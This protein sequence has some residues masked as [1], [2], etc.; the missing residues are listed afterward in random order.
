MMEIQGT[1]QDQISLPGAASNAPQTAQLPIQA[2]DADQLPREGGLSYDEV[3]SIIGSLY[4]D[5]HHAMKVREEQFQAILNEHE[6]VSMRLRAELQG[7]Q[8][9]VNRLV[10]EVTALRR[11]LEIR[12]DEGRQSRPTAPSSPDRPHPVSG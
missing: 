8:E 9:E 12:K 1:P 2:V 10:S 11:E 4:L 6:A 5:S 3:T 7:K